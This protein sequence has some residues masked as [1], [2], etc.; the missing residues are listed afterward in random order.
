[1]TKEFDCVEMK[2]RIQE[3]IYEETKDMTVQEKIKYFR[4]GAING[5]FG[6]LLKKDTRPGNDSAGKKRTA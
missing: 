2:H 5:E 4:D 6:Y 1:M 3:Q